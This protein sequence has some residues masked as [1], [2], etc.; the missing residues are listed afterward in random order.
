MFYVFI[1][2]TVGLTLEN[3]SSY[4]AYWEQARNLY[5]PFECTVTMK[6]GNADIYKNEIPGG[7]LPLG[8]ISSFLVLNEKQDRAPW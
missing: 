6:S 2:F 7:L 1:L 8:I 4:S 5:A 3:V